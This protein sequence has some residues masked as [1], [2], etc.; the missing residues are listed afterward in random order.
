MSPSVEFQAHAEAAVARSRA[1]LTRLRSALV[2]QMGRMSRP[3]QCRAEDLLLDLGR[4]HAKVADACLA[5]KEAD[6]SALPS[7]WRHF[8]VC[9][10]DYLEAVRDAKCQL[11]DEEFI[12]DMAAKVEAFVPAATLAAMSSMYSSSASWHFASRTASR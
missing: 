3:R 1:S 7:Q 5:M 10:D 4:R 11:A 8:L 2:A 9:Y 6:A 12:D